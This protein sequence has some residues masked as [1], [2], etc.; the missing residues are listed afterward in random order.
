MNTIKIYLQESGEIAE[1]RKDFNIYQGQYQSKLL[2]VYVPTSIVATKCDVKIGIKHLDRSGIIKQSR[3]FAMRYVKD[4]TYNGV[5]YA[6]FERLLP[7]EFT[8]YVGTDQNK[9]RLIIN[10]VDITDEVDPT[11]L[12]VI[13][14]QECDL[15][16]MPSANLYNDETLDPT[17]L[18]EINAELNALNQEMAQKQDK[19]DILLETTSKTV[20]GG[21]NENKGNIDTNTTNIASNSEQIAGLRNDIADLTARVESGENYIGQME[22]EDM[23]TSAQ[24][25]QFVE[26]T[27]AREATV[28]DVVIFV[29]DSD[30]KRNYKFT[31]YQSG[32]AGYEL[33]AVSKADNNIYGLLKG[34]YGID[35]A[36]EVLLDINNGEVLHIW[37]QDGATYRDLKEYLGAN[38]TN[39]TE[40]IN[41]TQAVG[42]AVKADQD[43]EG[44]NIVD[45]YLTQSAGATKEYVQDYAVPKVFSHVYFVTAEGYD[46]LDGTNEDPIFTETTSSVG[47]HQ[48]IKGDNVSSDLAM[49]LDADFEVS[50]ANAYQNTFWLEASADC[51]VEFK[52]TTQYQ[53]A[54]QEWT[55]LNVELSEQYSLTADTI[56]RVDFS[57]QFLSLGD[58]TVELVEGD[59]IRQILS[60]K[61]Q[62][63]DSITFDVYS[64]ET[65]PS[66]FNLLVSN[67][68]PMGA[69]T[70]YVDG[71]PVASWN[72]NNKSAVTSNSEIVQTFN[73]DTKADADNVYTKT[74]TD[75]LLSNYVTKTTEQE[76]SGAKTFT[77]N[78]TFTGDNTFKTSGTTYGAK[79]PNTTDWAANQ[80]LAT[81]NVI[82]NSNL[83]MNGNFWI[84][85]RGITSKTTDGYTAD[86]WY[87]RTVKFTQ[88]VGSK[89][90]TIYFDSN[91]VYAYGHFVQ[92]VSWG[93]FLTNKTVTLSVKINSISLPDSSSQV[94]LRVFNNDSVSTVGS[95][96]WDSEDIT[97]TG[98][99]TFTL[100][101][102]SSFTKTF[103]V[104]GV[105]LRGKNTSVTIEYIKLE[106]GDVATPHYPRLYNEELLLC[107]H[108]Y[109]KIGNSS[110][111]AYGMG[112]ND[113]PDRVI[114]NKDLI[115][116]MRAIP[117][118]NASGNFRLRYYSNN[119][120]SINASAITIDNESSST[121][122]IRLTVALPS[123]MTAEHSFM[124]TGN[125]AATYMEFDA[126]NY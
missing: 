11:V 32:W 12:S 48:I 116:E 7:K 29:L 121:N 8:M 83:L 43:G 45:T 10:V 87:L 4:I 3:N 96:Y 51:D 25:N 93:T 30:P 22:G 19:E 94:M 9:P 108:Y 98:I 14:C 33:T 50:I 60:V 105:A 81:T 71:S 111:L 23:P 1:L 52:L 46:G 101:L 84:N 27:V 126:E 95:I 80:T 73:A 15:D 31:Y 28:G 104:A 122:S 18:E 53:K 42:E 115:V 106:I 41:G 21:I 113:G 76:I 36:N 92:Q 69:T 49:T 114:I 16:V 103:L 75:T 100:T 67:Y 5:D 89:A 17:A 54:G 86:R 102:P 20:V 13:T 112:F 125:N 107:Q 77:G 82:P 110:Y 56:T 99:K 120:I 124:L 44:N 68:T 88:D 91:D 38:K 74:E 59:K 63:S 79:I 34:T 24:L 58:T 90:V 109:Q 35:S 117:T 47:E 119:N 37:V 78:N 65:Y 64:Y 72:A 85:Q 55:D 123:S 118:L 26:D 57:S 61:T 40:I 62:T 39:I 2:N 70:V 66:T 6:L 97:T